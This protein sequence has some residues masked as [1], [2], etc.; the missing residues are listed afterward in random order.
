MISTDAFADT[1]G[2]VPA[3]D[4]EKLVKLAIL[5]VRNGFAVVLDKPGEKVPLC[6]LVPAARKKADR[7]AQ[8]LA[9][10]A[11]DEH[12][13]RRRHACGLHHAFTNDAAV[14]RVL[15]R[16]IK[17]GQVPNIGV[18]VGRSKMIV[19]DVDTAAEKDAFLAEWTRHAD[20]DMTSMV[21]TVKSPGAKVDG[22]WVHKD[23]GHFWF[24]IPA[25]TELPEGGGVLRG[26]GGWAVLWRGKQVLVPPSSRAEGTY[27]LVGQANEAPAWLID[28]IQRGAAVQS[29]K[30]VAAALSARTGD[31]ISAK[32][33]ELPWS[34]ILT[35][36]GWIDTGKPDNCGCPIWTAPGGEHHSSKSA[37]AHEPGCAQYD[38]SQGQAPIHI[39]TDNPPD[40]VQEAINSLHGNRTFSKLNYLRFRL[41]D[42]DMARTKAGLGIADELIGGAFDAIDEATATTFSPEKADERPAKE[43]DEDDPSDFGLPSGD[44]GAA[45]PAG[46]SKPPQNPTLLP[47]DFWDSRPELAH[48]RQAARS[49]RIPPDA[50]IHGTLVRLAAMVP[51][52]LKVDTGILT[53]VSLNY[54][55]AIVG[56]SGFGKS[57]SVD[58]AEAILPG[59]PGLDDLWRRPLGSGEG[60][61]E[62]YMGSREEGTGEF[63]QS[64]PRQGEEKTRTVRAQIT[65]NALFFLD[66]GETLAKLMAERSGATLGQ[67]I[68]T[69]WTG[70]TLGQSNG[71]QE[72]TRIVR[73]YAMGLLIGY[74]PETAYSLL[75]GVMQGTPQRFMWGRVADPLAPDDVPGWP[76]E[77]ELDL[78][79]M[80]GDPAIDAP[81]VT[82]GMTLTLKREIDQTQLERLRG[83]TEGMD[84]FNSHRQATLI[85]IAGLLALLAGRNVI[86]EDDWELAKVMWRTSCAIRDRLIAARERDEIK[87][88]EDRTKR[89][90]ERATAVAKATGV[91]DG[92]TEKVARRFVSVIGEEGPQKIGYLNRKISPRNRGLI[93]DAV[94]MALEE[95]W[96]KRGDDDVLEI[97]SKR[98]E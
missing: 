13:A 74:Q 57:S 23:G 92:P 70:G 45:A 88:A 14:A 7:E 3:G 30:R 96:L 53:A 22:R 4:T 77:L 43:I 52:T 37:T 33:A 67:Q 90:V 62:A 55:A 78:S 87:K 40:Y 8:A 65:S 86:N 38:T 60:M 75:D 82:V 56:A 76:G 1:F 35:P 61:S 46:G 19:V 93:P 79:A 44:H 24:T 97:G 11:G 34:D 71:T 58:L 83:K 59:V 68:R 31:V 21:P 10:D 42:G 29:E 26:E 48:I 84:G 20:R 39:W 25:G 12:W 47:D 66:E 72:R 18:E 17:N 51:G 63:Y 6:T 16:L 64:G 98:P 27:Q 73:D 5:A 69:A 28:Y 15:R 80:L 32:M 95:G 89:D 91:L 41:Y 85:K 9:K 50:V 2:A 36:D 94:E 49:K 54:F 81:P